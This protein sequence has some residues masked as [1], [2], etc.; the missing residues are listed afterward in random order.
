MNR[1]AETGNRTDAGTVSEYK[2]LTDPAAVKE[3][4]GELMDAADAGD[5]A[6]RDQLI[7]SA[8]PAVR[9]AALSLID[10]HRNA[11]GMLL[12]ETLTGSSTGSGSTT[13]T[14]F[15]PATPP[16]IDGYE[17]GNEL[18][19]GG[20]GIVYAAQQLTPVR[21][22][23]AGK[24]L[25]AEFAT[26]HTAARFRAES[27]VLARMNHEG[28][29]RVLDAGLDR[30]GRAFVAMELIRGEP[31][32]DYAHRRELSVRQR[33]Q[34]MEQVCDAVHHAH[35]RAVLHRDLKPANILVEEADSKPRPRVIDFGIAKLLNDRAEDLDNYTTRDGQRMGTPRYMSP[36]QREGEREAD[37]RVDIYALGA[38]LCELLSGDVPH[39]QTRSGSQPGSRQPSRSTR[40]STIAAAGPP[41]LAPRAKQIRGDLDRIVLKATATDIAL[42]Y[43]SA[44]IFA[45]DLRRFL[46]GRPITATAPG[47]WYITRKFATRHRLPVSLAAGFL[48]ALVATLIIAITGWS[49][50]SKQRDTAMANAD[51]AAFIGDFLFE[52]LLLTTDID[53]RGTPPALTDGTIQAIA[54]R[55]IEGL[56]EDPENM[57]RVLE[58]I[59]RMQAQF[60]QAQDGATTLRHAL[61]FAIGHY[62][63]P[64]H[65]VIELRIHLHDL[66]WGHGLPGAREQIA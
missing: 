44:A 4:F 8:P 55:A 17:I 35:Q 25:R 65:E 51:R 29:A 63:I 48:L 20:F 2:P 28:I 9:Q 59:A 7:A 14:D 21:R 27:G 26:P 56:P 36:E 40:P 41:E 16:Q 58:G 19:R 43:N 10:A 13:H 24:V 57:L 47:F 53:T 39:P 32:T 5:H 45:E 34:L 66:L 23:V 60:Q 31:I 50:A 61:D 38:L 42:R 11:T 18:G 49:E 15:T 1:D 3:L 54:E 22:P 46:D 6:R 37:I 62:G 30:L 12:E 64:S 52:T 33:V